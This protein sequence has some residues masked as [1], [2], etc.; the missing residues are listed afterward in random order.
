VVHQ[1]YRHASCRHGEAEHSVPLPLLGHLEAPHD[2]E[3]SPGVLLLKPAVHHHH[4][5]ELLQDRGVQLGLRAGPPA[6]PHVV[7]GAVEPRQT[8]IAHPDIV[9]RLRGVPRGVV[10]L[11]LLNEVLRDRVGLVLL[12]EVRPVGHEGVDVGLHLRGLLPRGVPAPQRLDARGD[13]LGAVQGAHLPQTPAGAGA[14]RVHVEPVAEVVALSALQ[15]AGLR[16]E[17]GGQ[18]REVQGALLAEEVLQ[19]HRDDHATAGQRGEGHL[20]LPRDGGGE[21]GWALRR[22][23]GRGGVMEREAVLEQGG[24]VPP[25]TSP[26]HS[27]L[28]WG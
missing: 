17:G 2:G 22:H 6:D 28:P 1:S 8:D 11:E 10:L 20:A 15:L 27:T 3:D 16:P 26:A 12:V 4:H 14:E 9:G 23:R 21:R 18:V 19:A 25:R 24:G 7:L 5:Q 13:D